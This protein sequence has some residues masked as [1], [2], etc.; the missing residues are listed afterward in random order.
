MQSHCKHVKE[1]DGL[2]EYIL[3]CIILVNISVSVWMELNKHIEL[4]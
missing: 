4:F 2:F 3:A 1:D